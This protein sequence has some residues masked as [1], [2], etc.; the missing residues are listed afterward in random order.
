MGGAI[1]PSYDAS[2]ECIPPPEPLGLGPTPKGLYAAAP[3]K[4]S[5]ARSLQ[6]DPLDLGE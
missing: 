6:G 5:W 2:R 3:E 1:P 4:F